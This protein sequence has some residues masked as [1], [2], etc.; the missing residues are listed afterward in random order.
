MAA[1]LGFDAFYDF[2]GT[3]LNYG[4]ALN[5]GDGLPILQSPQACYSSLMNKYSVPA[6]IN[7]HDVTRQVANALA[8]DVGN[9]DLTAKLVP[10]NSTAIATVIT[11][12][13]AIVCGTA[14]FDEVFRQL[15]HTIKIRWH[16]KDGDP[17][18][19]GALLCELEGPARSLLTGER[20]A[21]NF[22]QTLSGTATTT[23]QYAQ[24]IGTTSC[25]VLDTRK[26]LPGL[27]LAQ[28]YAVSCGGGTNH[29]I[30]LFDAILIKENHII[31]A[32]SIN[33]AIQHARAVAGNRMVEIEVETLEE[34]QQALHKD[35]DRILV[36]NFSLNDMRAA[37]QLRNGYSHHRIDLEASGNVALG[38]IRSIA[39]TGV[40]FI[41]VG[42]LTKHVQAVDLSMRF[43]FS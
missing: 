6:D 27:R 5:Y 37:V 26:T 29:R 41:S 14:W 1:Q 24:A 20:S 36:D 8:E 7:M 3:Y 23:H 4:I 33:A 28:K 21:L 18:E 17:L 10:D 2:H 39:E 12:E 9:G 15:D 43:E 35:V 22:L 31:A 16:C 25:K 30:G 19:A 32:G 40:D 34:L 38:T 11:R 42:A 13:A